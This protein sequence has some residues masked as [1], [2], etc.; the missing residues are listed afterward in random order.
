MTYYHPVAQLLNNGIMCGLNG[1][2]MFNQ[3]C[4]NVA[5]Q[6]GFILTQM[7]FKL[8]ETENHASMLVLFCGES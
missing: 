1:L 3:P 4:E 7:M 2:C 8:C 5:C 6:L